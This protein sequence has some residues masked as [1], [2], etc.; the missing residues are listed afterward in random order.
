M[1]P[2]PAPRSSA[3]IFRRNTH[4]VSSYALLDDSRDVLSQQLLES[5]LL[6]GALKDSLRND[7]ELTRAVVKHVRMSIDQ[8]ARIR[9]PLKLGVDVGRAEVNA[10]R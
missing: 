10:L 8:C 4:P 9:A 5:L 6:L 1:E 2:F 7:R 3:V